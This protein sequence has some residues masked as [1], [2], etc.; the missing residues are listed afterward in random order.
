MTRKSERGR[1]RPATRSSA[2]KGPASSDTPVRSSSVHEWVV[3]AVI[4]LVGLLLRTSYLSEIRRLPAFDYPILDAATYDYW[5]RGL[6]TGDW[7]VDTQV[8]GNPQIRETPFLRPPGY[9]YFVGLVY[10]LT[11][12][13]RLAIRLVQMGLGLASAVLLFILGR[14]MFG[15]TVGLLAAG[16]MST[17]WVFIHFEG[18]LSPTTLSVFLLLLLFYLVRLWL[19]RR[20]VAYAL[21]A[22]AVLGFLS[23]TRPESMILVPLIALW[24][25]RATRAA[26]PGTAR[27]LSLAAFCA[28]T[29]LVILPA[30]IRNYAVSKE[31]VL[32]C[33]MGGPNLYAGNNEIADG[34]WPHIDMMRA[35]GITSPLTDWDFPLYLQVL[36]SRRNNPHLG[37]SDLSSHFAGLAITYVCNNPLRTLQLMGKKAL[38]FWGPTETPNNTVIYMDKVTSPTLK[39]LPG[40]AAVVALFVLGTVLLVQQL[41]SE[42]RRRKA[43]DVPTQLCVLVYGFVTLHFLSIL[44]FFAASRYRVPITPFLL[45]IAGYA[46]WTLARFVRQRMW[47]KVTASLSTCAFV[48]L[49]SYAC[50]PSF[51]QPVSKWHFDRG[52]A[53]NLAGQKD[54]AIEEVRQAAADPRCPPEY[55]VELAEVLKGQGQVDEAFRWYQQ[56]IAR[57]PAYADAHNAMGQAL[58]EFGRLDEAIRCFEAALRLNPVYADVHVNWAVALIRA[59]R[60]PEAEGHL[61]QAMAIDPDNAWTYHN[62]GVSLSAQG[63]T[64]EGI[65]QFREALKRN[66]RNAQTH[67]GLAYELRKVG[68][69]DEALTHYRRAVAI[70]PSFVQAHIE[71][72][73]LLLDLHRYDEAVR[74][75]RDVLRLAPA[76]LAVYKDLGAA[77]AGSGKDAEAI[78]CYHKALEIRPDWA[79]LMNNLA[80]L[81]ATSRDAALRD[82]SQAIRL[83]SRVCE[84]TRGERP[85]PLDT[86][87]AAQA[88]AGQFDQ[89]IVTVQKGLD[90][91]ARAGK[92]DL[93]RQMK[94]RLALYQASRPFH[95][96]AR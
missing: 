61:R 24:A 15:R 49:L 43:P 79:E 45:L 84:L 19:D 29:F 7:T 89:A 32:I 87:A 1:P 82:G 14:R 57:A 73:R 67:N 71:L 26:D 42:W 81:L 12:C 85:E 16:L 55:L 17:Y 86:L 70:N 39:H 33:T 59:R 47:G 69:L 54:L 21:G 9:P 6:A 5:G 27:A 36:R 63:R 80:W 51:E 37:Y 95:E 66:D 56:A 10:K 68:R 64:L 83:A 8:M 50:R 62:L 44:L 91:A 94:E 78:A 40:F 75:Y 41:A 90:L 13:S 38:L 72:G 58:S 20:T 60:Y 18:E 65:E 28:G 30:T 31:L 46:L 3:L 25:W 74:E 48:F 11:G 35:L 93:V 76:T 92:Q 2:V 4:V 22:G 88:E 23:L 77:L 34:A 96:P 53:Y 52:V